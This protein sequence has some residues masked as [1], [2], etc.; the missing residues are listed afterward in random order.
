MIIAGRQ[1]SNH[2]CTGTHYHI[3]HQGRIT[4]HKIECIPC[5]QCPVGSGAASR[6]TTDADTVCEACMP[7]K[8]YSTTADRHPCR[9]CRT[10]GHARIISQC[11]P[12]QNTK[13]GGCKPGKKCTNVLLYGY[14]VIGLGS[15]LRYIL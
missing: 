7:G 15:V 10:C 14:F 3:V 11:Q 6:C 2:N 9:P 8:S 4:E 5:T 13:C 1:R 12:H